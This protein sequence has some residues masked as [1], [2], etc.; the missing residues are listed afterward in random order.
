VLGTKG[1]V[2]HI[3]TFVGQEAHAGSTPMNQRRDALA[4]AAKLALEVRTI[5]G[6]HPDAVCTIG[7]VKTLP[8]IA[9]AVVGRCELTLDQRDL[10]A[11][12]L[13]EMLSEARAASERFAAEEGCTVEWQRIFGVE[14]VAFHPELVALCEEAVIETAGKSHRMPSGPLHDGVE[15]MRAG[16][17]AAMMFVQ[18]LRGI[19]HNRIEDTKR[20]HL[21]M[22]VIAFDRLAGKAMEWVA[23]T[24]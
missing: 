10:D 7:S 9:T 23:K 16:I 19:S 21:A 5:A 24:G 2:R 11:D 13:A 12:V 15:V 20:E 8:G 22:S 17:P 6:R 1:L 14:P 3:V 4:A 18:S